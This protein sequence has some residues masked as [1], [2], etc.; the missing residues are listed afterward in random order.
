[1]H[2]S[3]VNKK[4]L[5]VGASGFIGR[6]LTQKLLKEGARVSV[7][8]RK[9]KDKNLFGNRKI[10]YCLGDLLYYK[11]LLKA[12]KGIEIVFNTSGA[13]PYHKL[14]DVGYKQ[15]NVYGVR[16]LMKAATKNKVKR[17]V[18]IS[19]VGIYGNNVNNIDET[20]EPNPTDAYSK[21]KLSG[22]RIVKKYQSKNLSTVIIRPTIAYGPYDTRPV[23][24]TLF[25]LVKNKFFIMIGDGKNYFHTVYVGNLVDAIL[26]CAQK[27][28]ADGEDFIIGDD[29]CPKFVDLCNAIA[30]SMN[31]KISKFYIPRTLVFLVFGNFISRKLNFIMEQK[32]YRI[33]KAKKI[34]GYKPKVDLKN[35]IKITYGW[36]KDNNLI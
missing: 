9:N 32:R 36:Y 1:M 35:G 26:L 24:L 3:L 25:K 33:D 23:I 17:V 30:K 16:N 10:N 7:L 28:D 13:L 12:T 2:N 14:S 20:T 19:T 8:I 34:L 27:E 4:V 5:V 29:P 11:S 18:H 31:K 15:V 22:E 21:S 6:N